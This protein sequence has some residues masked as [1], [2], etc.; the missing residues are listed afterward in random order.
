MT[1]TMIADVAIGNAVP[2]PDAIVIVVAVVADTVKLVATPAVKKTHTLSDVVMPWPV[3][4][5]RT[6]AVS[7]VLVVRVPL[8]PAAGSSEIEV[9][10][11]S[12]RLITLEISAP[13]SVVV[14]VTFA[15]FAMLLP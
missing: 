7:L 4:T 2:P 12:E 8:L 3:A 5:V 1:E 14:I 13:A 6:P 10:S 11:S 15:F 9:A